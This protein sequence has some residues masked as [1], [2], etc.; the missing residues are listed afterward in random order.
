MKN[1][2]NIIDNKEYQHWFKSPEYPYFSF[3]QVALAQFQE[4][5]IL[6]ARLAK[7]MKFLSRS[8]NNLI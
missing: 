7:C 1:E 5:P 4:M 2:L 3:V 6:Q 8:Q